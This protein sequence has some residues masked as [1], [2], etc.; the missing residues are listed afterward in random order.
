M[1]GW[2]NLTPSAGA[3]ATG[4]AYLYESTGALM[5]QGTSGSAATLVN[6][7]GTKPANGFSIT[8]PSGRYIKTGYFSG[9]TALVRYQLQ[10]ARP[11][12]LTASHTFT[13]IGIETGPGNATAS[14]MNLGIYA[15][16]TDGLPSTLVLDAGAVSPTTAASTYYEIIINQTLAAGRYWLAVLPTSAAMSTLKAGSNS[17]EDRDDSVYFVQSLTS[18]SPSMAVASGYGYQLGGQLTMPA[19][20]SGYSLST[21]C[22]PPL[23]ALKVA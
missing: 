21:T 10:F 22:W 13:R 18:G 19:T 8:I 2:T 17:W 14:T 4:N 1:A 15:S 20:A 7:D 9:N 16:G 11:I 23:M 6:A 3:L 12:L 5:Y